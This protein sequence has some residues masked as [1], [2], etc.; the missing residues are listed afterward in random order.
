MQGIQNK[1][2][3]K[4][5]FT[6]LEVM[7]AMVIFAV[8]MLGLAGIQALSLD[9]SHSSYS[10]S[11]AILLA[12]DM[13]DR[14]KAN[15]TAGTTYVIATATSVSEPG[16]LCDASACGDTLMAAFDHWQWKTQ[17]PILLLSG[18]GKIV[19]TGGTNYSI[20]VFWD[21]DRTGA[22]DTDNCPP[23]SVDDMRCVQLI[24]RL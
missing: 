7:I 8:G 5:G 20:T 15:P 18:K 13:V 12:Y 17:L 2:V 21:E 19:N 22:T 4:N 3:S 6:L 23:T 9:N 11:Q 24:T 16:T 1:I 10:R 14:M